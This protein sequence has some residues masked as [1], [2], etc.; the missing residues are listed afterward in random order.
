[1]EEEVVND[2]GAI[3]ARLR[4]A[5]PR[6][7]SGDSPRRRLAA[8]MS[9]LLAAGCGTV[10]T[11]APAEPQVVT[12]ESDGWRLE[13]VWRPSDT[14][15][16]GRAA[17]LLHR[18]AGSRAEYDDLAD[19][20]AARGVSTLALDLRGHGASTNLGRFQPPYAE[21]LHIN[22]GAS[23]DV[24][25]GLDWMGSRPGLDAGRLAVVGASYSGEVAARAG[26]E[27][28]RHAAAYVMLSPG[29]FSAESI[30]AAVR[31]DADW[32]FVRT[33]DESATSREFIDALFA[34]LEADAPAL[35]R[36]TVPGAGHATH[37]LE[38]RPS[39]VAEIADWIASALD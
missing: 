30:A 13:G 20:L 17:L 35:Q 19:A 6:R 5:W 10:D 15:N 16:P 39:L 36:R 7:W 21:H 22:E 34:A 3:A 1:M 12:I 27:E 33:V 8:M 4:C 29:N 31:G 26:R 9:V 37:M 25:A 18:A 28:G 38:D 23:R 2:A 11:P 24:A 14:G 32:L